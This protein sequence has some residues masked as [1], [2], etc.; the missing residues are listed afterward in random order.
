MISSQLTHVSILNI[1]SSFSVLK[2]KQ[3]PSLVNTF[4]N[5]SLHSTLSSR[6]LHS[7]NTSSNSGATCWSIQYLFV[8]GSEILLYLYSFN[9]M[10]IFVEYEDFHPIP[11]LLFLLPLFIEQFGG[12][13]KWLS[14][15]NH[16]FFDV[17]TSIRSLSMW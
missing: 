15:I 11:F 8:E 17:K 9:Y 12:L 16:C 2:V 6:Q 1:S 3:N 13:K 10:K 7:S 4:S 14:N 5:I